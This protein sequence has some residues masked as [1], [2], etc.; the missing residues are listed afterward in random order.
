MYVRLL[1]IGVPIRDPDVAIW[2]YVR[3][4]HRNVRCFSSYVSDML[5]KKVS[6]VE[7]RLTVRREVAAHRNIMD[8]DANDFQRA[9]TARISWLQ[10]LQQ[11]T[12]VCDSLC[13]SVLTN[14]QSLTTKVLRSSRQG[15]KTIN[16]WI[17]C[18]MSFFMDVYE[19]C[20][21]FP[22]RFPHRWNSRPFMRRLANMGLDVEA[23]VKQLVSASIICR[24]A[25]SGC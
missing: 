1:S 21:W 17:S 22:W 13:D 6:Y 7:G 23:E 14:S 16:R 19:Y 8:W 3:H 4:P 24:F 2:L 9:I 10:I 25:F 11:F 12:G 18:V 5:E 20:F 15:R